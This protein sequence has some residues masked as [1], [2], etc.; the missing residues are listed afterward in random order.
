MRRGAVGQIGDSR[1]GVGSSID[2]KGLHG[3]LL[4]GWCRLWGCGAG[5]PC[6]RVG[7]GRGLRRSCGAR[8]FLWRNHDDFR[9]HSL[10]A[11]CRRAEQC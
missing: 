8:D 3:L 11:Y 9:L 5:V 7:A 6:G 4:A 2:L 1:E 10:T